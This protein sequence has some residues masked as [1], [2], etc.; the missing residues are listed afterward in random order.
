MN[1]LEFYKSVVRDTSDFL[2]RLIGALE[3][4]NIRYCVIGGMAVNA[5]AEPVVTLDLDLVVAVEQIE[6]VKD[7]LETKFSVHEF[8]HTL[9]VSLLGSDLRVQIQTDR[10]FAGFAER[11]QERTVLGM[12]LPVANIHDL[13]QSKVWAAQ[14]PARRPSKQIKDLSDIVRL[15][16]VR[17]DLVDAVP[18][19]VMA[20]IDSAQAKG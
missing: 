12:R 6:N 10:Q 13:L 17:P 3:D 19:D 5:Y 8:P 18:A 16:E 20:R 14:E 1:A 2:A 15:L 11:A 4:H 7:I 9:N